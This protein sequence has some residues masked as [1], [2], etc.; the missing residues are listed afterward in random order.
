MINKY[1]TKQIN[2][3]NICHVIKYSKLVYYINIIKESIKTKCGKM[4]YFSPTGIPAYRIRY[5]L[6]DF[7]LT[8]YMNGS[9][10]TIYIYIY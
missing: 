4:F 7:N 3:V 1:R 10:Y 8:A 2:R 9:H 6:N 5:P